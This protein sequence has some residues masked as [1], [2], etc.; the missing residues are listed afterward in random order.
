MSSFDIE[1]LFT[2]IHLEETTKMCANQ[3]FKNPDI[4]PVLKKSESKDLPDLATKD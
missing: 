3:L 2:N 1:T 4:V